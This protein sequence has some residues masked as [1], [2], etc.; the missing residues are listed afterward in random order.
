MA[1]DW[2]ARCAQML[3]DAERD[4]VA[5]VGNSSLCA[6]GRSGDRLD[7]VKYLEG[8]TTALREFRRQLGDTSGAEA[9]R[10]VEQRWQDHLRLALNRNMG[11]DWVAYR[12]GGVDALTDLAEHEHRGAPSDV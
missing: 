12:T 2:A 11:P 9:H 6:I 7:G 4:L 3:T 10:E 5:A 8:R 1:V